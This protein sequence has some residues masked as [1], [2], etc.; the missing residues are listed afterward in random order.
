MEIW[1]YH[2]ALLIDWCFNVVLTWLVVIWRR[3]HGLRLYSQ[4]S[5][6]L[7]IIRKQEPKTSVLSVS[8]LMCTI[9]QIMV[10]GYWI[11]TALMWLKYCRNDVNHHSINQSALHELLH[12]SLFNIKSRSYIEL[13]LTISLF[14][15][16]QYSI[17]S[18]MAVCSDDYDVNTLWRWVVSFNHYVVRESFKIAHNE[19]KANYSL[20]CRLTFRIKKK[21]SH[22]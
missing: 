7:M 2:F 11:C 17:K 16:L 19:E 22:N 18:S 14:V 13:I 20:W 4:K 9:S 6:W 12:C 1:H 10:G 15:A 5:I 8:N 3:L 21:H